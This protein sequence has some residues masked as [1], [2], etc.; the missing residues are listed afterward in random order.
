MQMTQPAIYSPSLALFTSMSVS[1][2]GVVSL[3]PSPHSGLEP[4]ITPLSH[5]DIPNLF[6]SFPSHDRVLPGCLLPAQIK[7]Y[8]QVMPAAWHTEDTKG[9]GSRGAE[10]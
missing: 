1:G 3:S 5:S 4:I 7:I 8:N 2:W 9:L 6:K 10:A